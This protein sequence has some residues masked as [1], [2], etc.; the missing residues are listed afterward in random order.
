M[1]DEDDVDDKEE[2]YDGDA[3]TFSPQ[4]QLGG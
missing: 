1:D 3:A 2:N 4:V